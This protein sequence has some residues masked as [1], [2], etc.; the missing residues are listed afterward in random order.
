[1]GLT[2]TG[3]IRQQMM[4]LLHE[5]DSTALHISQML[6]ISEKEVFAHL[7]HIRRSAASQNRMLTVSPAR[8]LECGYTFEDRRRVTKPGRCPR[9]KGE[10]VQDPTFRID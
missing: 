6:K 8:C 2:V 10:H 4:E 1:M 9:C 3:T 5:N 7:D